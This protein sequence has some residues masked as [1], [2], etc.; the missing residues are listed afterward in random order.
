MK[1][2]K[3]VLFIVILLPLLAAVYWQEPT[4]EAAFVA[5]TDTPVP[6]DTPVP[7]STT[8]PADT[9]VPTSTVMPVDTP[10]PTVT[11]TPGGPTNTPVSDPPSDDTPE[12]NTPV[13]T[14]SVIPSLGNGPRA[15]SVLFYGSLLFMLFGVVTVGWLKVWQAYRQQNQ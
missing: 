13:E 3:V 11:N 12:S 10:V 15:D 7:T 6:P 1:N 5:V 2:F 14:P 4:V 9:P 8:V